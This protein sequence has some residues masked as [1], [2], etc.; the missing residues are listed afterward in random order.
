MSVDSFELRNYILLEIPELSYIAVNVNGCRAYVQV[1]E[2]TPAPE[3]VSR[4]APGNTVAAKDV[5]WRKGCS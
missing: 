3:L 4:R 2:R 1:R 5:T